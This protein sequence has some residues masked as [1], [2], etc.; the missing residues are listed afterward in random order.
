[1]IFSRHEWH[2]LHMYLHRSIV[3]SKP[4]MK[5]IAFYY[6]LQMPLTKA[7]KSK[8]YRERPGKIYDFKRKKQSKIG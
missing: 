6:L 4:N 8:R 5:L 3:L 2:D 7:E 1:M